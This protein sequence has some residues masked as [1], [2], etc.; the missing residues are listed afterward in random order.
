[1]LFIDSYATSSGSMLHFLFVNRNLL[2]ARTNWLRVF[3]RMP[4]GNDFGKATIATIP[5]F[6]SQ[7]SSR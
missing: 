7:E 4:E 5:A 6:F 1:V 2:A 3:L